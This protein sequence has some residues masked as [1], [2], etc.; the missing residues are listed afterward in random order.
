MALRSG[1]V[2][3]PGHKAR[4]TSPRSASISDGMKGAVTG[5]AAVA[6]AVCVSTAANA[7][8]KALP[9]R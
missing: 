9:V 2:R 4:V 3:K 8:T 1:A 7:K 5:A 6:A